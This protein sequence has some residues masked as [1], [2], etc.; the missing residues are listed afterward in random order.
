VTAT[1]RKLA[2]LFDSE[3]AGSSPVEPGI[4]SGSYRRDDLRRV[5]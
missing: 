5:P 1:A 2:N 3:V 4:L